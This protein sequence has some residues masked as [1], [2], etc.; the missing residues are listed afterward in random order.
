M[1]SAI[2]ASNLT[3]FKLGYPKSSSPQTPM[4]DMEIINAI[5]ASL[6]IIEGHGRL[7]SIHPFL[8]PLQFYRYLAHF[9]AW[10]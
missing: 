3:S 9:N 5:H 1:D 6:M 8:I 10:R 2:P 4:E 7:P